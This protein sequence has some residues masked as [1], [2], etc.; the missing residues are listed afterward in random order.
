[1][2]YTSPRQNGNFLAT[3]SRVLRTEQS[4]TS[5]T[6]QSESSTSKKRNSSSSLGHSSIQAI[7]SGKL[8]ARVKSRVLT[9][10]GFSGIIKEPD[11]NLR[12]GPGTNFSIVGNLGKS[13]GQTRRFDGWDTGTPVW[14][15]Q[16]KAYDNKWFRLAGT[17]QW[18]T[19]AF[20]NGNPPPTPTPTPSTSLF[21]NPTSSNPLRGFKDPSNGKGSYS[22]GHD[23]VQLYADDIALPLGTGVNVMRSG[24]VIALQEGF[25][26]TSSG[27]A[28]GPQGQVGKANQ[29]NTNYVLVEHDQDVKNANG[30][31]YR[32]LYLHVQYN[33]VRPNV[34]DRVNTGDLIAS[35]GN[36]GWSTG[37][38]LHVDVNYSTG[39]GVFQRQT[40]PYVWDN[41][42]NK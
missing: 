16:A 41:G 36:N 27:L 34:G 25:R 30:K 14:D 32:S 9:V 35:V 7:N 39:S 37:P 24:R 20:I 11:I 10:V 33:S 13:V 12:S 38:H 8:P 40:V 4:H 17:N 15:A 22:S 23:G 28:V 31:P 29:F 1:M 42:R 18:V 5:R 21:P 6:L 19:S 2:N 26:D 3:N